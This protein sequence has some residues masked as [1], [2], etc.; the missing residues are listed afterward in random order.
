[1]T[2]LIFDIEAN[3]LLDTIDTIWCIG[4]TDAEGGPVDIYTDHDSDYRPLQEGLDR[5]SAADTVVAHNGLGYDLQAINMLYPNTLR[6]EQMYDTMVAGML[7]E[8]E[9]RSHAIKS[10]GEQFKAPKGDFSDFSRYSKEMVTYME[11]DVKIGLKVYQ[12][13]SSKITSQKAL[14][15]EHKVQWTIC[16][17]ERHGY[18]LDVE[19][20]QELASELRGE[21]ADIEYRLEQVF[22]EQYV[23]KK[24][25]WDWTECRWASVE[26]ITPKTDNKR[27]AYTKGA[28]FCAIKPEMFNPASRAQIARRLM[29]K[30]PEWKPSVWTTTGLPKVDEKTLGGLDYPEAKLMNRY[31]TVAKMLGQLSD[32]K[33]GWLKLVTEQGYVHG[34]VK[35]IGCRTHRSSHFSPNMA[36]VSKKDLRMRS[37]WIPD[38]G[39]VQVGCDASGLELR[40]LGHY[41]G[42]YDGGEYAEAVVNGTSADGTDAHTK[43]QRAVGYHSRDIVKA[44]TYATLY[45]AGNSK[46]GE[47]TNKDRKHGGG[48]MVPKSQ[49]AKLGGQIRRKVENGI[50]GFGQLDTVCKAKDK[51]QGYVKGLDGR[52]VDTAGQHS[53]L[54]TV[55]Q[56]A[57][58]IV[59]KKAIELFHFE[60]CKE[61]GLVDDQWNPVGWHYL[62]QVHDEVQFSCEPQLAEQIGQLFQQSITL[63]GERLKLRCVL[64]GEYM[65]GD[66]WASCH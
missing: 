35:S 24:A 64:D 5:L 28:S 37:V 26:T 52:K 41:L 44:L 42:R 34:R 13:V 33:N 20:A 8:P 22:G 55:L 17:M 21:V 49:E 48:K 16:L 62:A 60:L 39:H 56:S 36:Q 29:S 1:M 46:L 4:I 12:Y 51:A 7:A 61:A 50:R 58:A 53:A 54:N 40:M 65:I 66:S 31:L 18:R 11:Q 30:Y 47:I 38:E 27:Y 59:M 45:G 43:M 19:K 25:T 63:A 15:T 3:G 6:F 2:T 23:P 10:Y 32:G 9:R 14:E 57:G